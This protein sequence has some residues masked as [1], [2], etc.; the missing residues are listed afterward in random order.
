MTRLHGL[1]VSGP[2]LVLLGILV[3]GCGVRVERVVAGDTLVV[4]GG[5]RVRLVGVQTYDP[6]AKEIGRSARAFTAQFLRSR[7]VLEYD[8]RRKDK[9]GTAWAYV[10]ARGR[11]LNEELLRNGHARVILNF[12]HKQREKYQKLEQ[13]AVDARK[14]IWASKNAR[15]GR[16][17]SRGAKKIIDGYK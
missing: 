16:S 17:V 9:D 1:T 2:P 7:A 10:Y 6:E 11:C 4:S 14:G 8:E 5:K 12:E 13:V 15:F 3:S